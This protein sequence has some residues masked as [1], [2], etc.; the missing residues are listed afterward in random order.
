MHLDCLSLRRKDDGTGEETSPMEYSQLLTRAGKYRKKGRGTGIY[1]G[2]SLELS[3]T[4]G[5]STSDPTW[6]HGVAYQ[7]IR[8][9]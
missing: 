6:M 3:L 8:S 7:T 5:L 4:G 2:W 1:L 9:L